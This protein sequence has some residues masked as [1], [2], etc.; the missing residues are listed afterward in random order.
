MYNI[1]H[2][3]IMTGGKCNN[4]CCVTKFFIIPQCS[5]RWSLDSEKVD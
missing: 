4:A 1:I 2:V 5:F 3:Q